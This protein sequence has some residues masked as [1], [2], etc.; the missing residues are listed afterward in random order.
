[1]LVANKESV[2]E[3]LVTDD[4]KKFMTESITLEY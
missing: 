4:F 3:S 1:M 2:K